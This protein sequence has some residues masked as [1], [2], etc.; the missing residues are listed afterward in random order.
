MSASRVP[1][2]ERFGPRKLAIGKRFH[3]E[4]RSRL[5]QGNL[6]IWLVVRFESS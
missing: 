4:G 3:F 1:V 6:P 2:S 5:L